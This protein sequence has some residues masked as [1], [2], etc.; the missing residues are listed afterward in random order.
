[1]WLTSFL[2]SPKVRVRFCYHNAVYQTIP[3]SLPGY[4][5]KYLFSTYGSTTLGYSQVG[6]IG[7]NKLDQTQ[8]LGCFRSALCVFPQG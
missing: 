7:L 5:N 2:S 6:F 3:K 1:M 4:E 8:T